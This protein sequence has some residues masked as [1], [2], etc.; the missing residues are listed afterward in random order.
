L[1]PEQ[2]AR[3]REAYAKAEAERKAKW[4]ADHPNVPKWYVQGATPS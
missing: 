4:E 1:K 2:E 3:D